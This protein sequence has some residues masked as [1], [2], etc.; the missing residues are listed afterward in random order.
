MSLLTVDDLQVEGKRVLM[1]VD[2]NVPLD[3]N[4]RIT[5]DFRIQAAIPTINKLIDQ[6]ARVVLMSHLGRP[7]GQVVKELSLKPVAEYLRNHFKHV[8]FTTD[9]VGDVAE[10]IVNSAKKGSVILLENLRFHAG[11]KANDP[12]FAEQL[13]ALGD[14][15]VNNAFGTCHRAHASMAG[16]AEHFEQRAIGDLVEKEIKFLK[17]KVSNP[18]H[19]YTAV[20]GGAKVSDKIQIIDKIIKKADHLLIGGGMCFTFLKAKGYDVGNSLVEEEKLDLAKDLMEKAKEVNCKLTLP[21]D[22]VCAEEM[23]ENVPAHTVDVDSIPDGE[24]GLDIGEKTIDNFLEILEN[25]KTVLWNGPM[26][27]FEIEK[28]SKGTFK[29]AHKLAD[30]TAKGAI[31]IIGGGDSASAIKEAG[32]MEQVSHV[33]T[34]G[35]ASLALIGGEKMEPLE[36]ISEK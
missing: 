5:D 8:A 14:V 35:G 19:P 28:F 4:Q 23:E 29:I 13:S 27:V 16:V 7:K 20:M 12:E 24:M 21:V 22:V 1:R 9:C 15:Y 26:G 30:I 17:G 36:L 6:G 10:E 31:T 2:F 25:S 11:E 34:G 32:L 3:N 33:S 18:T